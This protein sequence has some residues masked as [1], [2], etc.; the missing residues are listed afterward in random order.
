MRPII[1][2]FIIS[3]IYCHCYSLPLPKTIWNFFWGLSSIFRTSLLCRGELKWILSLSFF[4]FNSKVMG[5]F[6]C[7]PHFI[8]RK[9]IIEC[10]L[11]TQIKPSC[12]LLHAKFITAILFSTQSTHCQRVLACSH[13]NYT[14]IS[15]IN[16]PFALNK[17]LRKKALVSL[18]IYQMKCLK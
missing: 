4:L 6:W 3:K 18:P 10:C 11:Y 13:L 12:Y 16:H 15:K 1:I 7:S 17:C 8:F 5:L 9:K 2:K 14:M